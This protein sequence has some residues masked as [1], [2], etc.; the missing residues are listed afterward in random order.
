M[1]Q[2][3]EQNNLKKQ[4]SFVEFVKKEIVLITFK[5]CPIHRTE[6]VSVD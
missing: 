1:T 4:N 3:V 2:I 5:P 6:E